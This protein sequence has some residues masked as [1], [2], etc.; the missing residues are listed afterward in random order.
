MATL[1]QL[2]H[3]VVGQCR[4]TIQREMLISEYM[5]MVEP[6]VQAHYN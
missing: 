5:S 1:T 2:I 3:D 4:T 6:A